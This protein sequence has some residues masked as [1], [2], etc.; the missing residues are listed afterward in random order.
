MSGIS[1]IVPHNADADSL[2]EKIS[3]FAEGNTESEIINEERELS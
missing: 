2:M 3:R 1:G